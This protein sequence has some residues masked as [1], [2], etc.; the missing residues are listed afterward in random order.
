MS[1]NLSNSDT[2]CVIS[3]LCNMALKIAVWFCT[4]WDNLFW[5]LNSLSIFASTVCKLFSS[6][7]PNRCGLYN[8]KD[9]SFNFVV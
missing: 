4:M 3:G 8:V 7:V 6:K 9:A 1:L 5:L 2:R